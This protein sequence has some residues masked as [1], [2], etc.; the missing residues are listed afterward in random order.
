MEQTFQ[1]QFWDLTTN[2]NSCSIEVSKGYLIKLVCMEKHYIPRN[3]KISYMSAEIETTDFV[4]RI[5][6]NMRVSI[7]KEICRVMKL[8]EGDYVKIRIRKVEIK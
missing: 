8:K 2:F 1:V 3:T 7:P 5:V 4:R 6:S